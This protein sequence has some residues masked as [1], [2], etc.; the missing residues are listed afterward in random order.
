MYHKRCINTCVL[1][2]IKLLREIKE[3]LKK[4]GDYAIFIDQKTQY[5]RVV[6]LPKLTYRFNA[7]PVKET[8]VPQS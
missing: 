7:V 8:F 6:D 2:T 4:M 3:D 5:S 1:K